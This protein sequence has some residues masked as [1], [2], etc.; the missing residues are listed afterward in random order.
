MDIYKKLKVKYQDIEEYTEESGEWEELGV[1]A[2]KEKRYSDAISTFQ[3]VIVAIPDHFNAY[4]MCGYALYMN[5]DTSSAID[6]L[7]KAIEICKGYEREAALPKEFI[8][9]IQKNLDKVRGQL[10]LDEKYIEEIM[11]L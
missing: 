7:E 10:K 8:E 9:N 11:E 3:K 5:E 4:E 1:L 6:Y 2:Y